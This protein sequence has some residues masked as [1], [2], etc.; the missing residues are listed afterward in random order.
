MR[1]RI[2]VGVMWWLAVAYFWNFAAAMYEFP[3]GIGPIL[4]L[5]VAILFAAD[6]LKII[7]PRNVRRIARIPDRKVPD[8]QGLLTPRG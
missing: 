7:W 8:G 3:R 2:F 1:K 6:P 5:A 4:A